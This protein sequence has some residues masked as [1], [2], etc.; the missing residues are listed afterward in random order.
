MK[1]AIPELP[2]DLSEEQSEVRDMESL[3]RGLPLREPTPHLD[4][5][6]ASLT[7]RAKWVQFVK[8]VGFGIAAMVAGAIGLE[9][10]LHNSRPFQIVSTQ[11]NVKP[12]PGPAVDPSRHPEF[13]PAPRPMLVQHISAQVRDD[14]VIGLLGNTP[15]QRYRKHSVQQIWLLD[16]KTGV[17]TSITIPKDEVVL[18]KVQP[19]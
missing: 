6:I 17:K 11:P 12:L 10:L 15:V 8:L 5:Q 4:R 19:F 1:D 3:L 9:P 13:L 7:R 18:R 16:P 14:G 2:D